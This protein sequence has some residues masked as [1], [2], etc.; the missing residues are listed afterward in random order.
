MSCACPQF[1]NKLAPSRKAPRL[2][3]VGGLGREGAPV[4]RRG[5]LLP[6]M[7]PAERAF[8]L[9][10]PAG[11]PAHSAKRDDEEEVTEGAG[12]ASDP[13]VQ[14]A[15]EPRPADHP[16]AHRPARLPVSRP[17]HVLHLRL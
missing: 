17:C 1:A 11:G 2:A 10:V 13:I 5:S 16:A 12:L 15:P 9:G 6:D 4:S 8:L 7:S 3:A 14:S